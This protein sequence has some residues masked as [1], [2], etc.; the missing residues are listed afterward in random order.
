MKTNIQVSDSTNL[1]GERAPD[2]GKPHGQNAFAHNLIHGARST[3]PAEVEPL[4]V[5]G[6]PLVGYDRYKW[7]LTHRK[8][9][10]GGR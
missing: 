1:P 7:N 6:Q 3:T 10:S 8:P 4:G 9:A 5:D 2:D